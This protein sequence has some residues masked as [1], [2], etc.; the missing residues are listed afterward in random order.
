MHINPTHLKQLS[1]QSFRKTATRVADSPPLPPN[2]PIDDTARLPRLM[3]APA[4]RHPPG[5]VE[6]GRNQRHT[7]TP[8]NISSS[9]QEKKSTKK[10]WSFSVAWLSLSVSLSLLLSRSLP[11]SLFFKSPH[12][13]V[14]E[15][16]ADEVGQISIPEFDGRFHTV[17]PLSRVLPIR[18]PSRY[19]S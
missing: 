12:R 16:S 11:L 15:K 8:T 10:V 19:V 5:V 17:S 18:T 14:Q 1:H 2:M 4:R 3:S 7:R 13:R 6:C 9:A